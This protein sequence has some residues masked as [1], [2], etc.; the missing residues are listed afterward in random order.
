MIHK[1]SLAGVSN[2]NGNKLSPISSVTNQT[3]NISWLQATNNKLTVQ[4]NE[5]EKK[6]RAK[7]VLQFEE[8]KVKHS[9]RNTPVT[10]AED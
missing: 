3:S 7:L 10:W 8:V 4:P 5:I 1:E 2:G 9:L 6:Q